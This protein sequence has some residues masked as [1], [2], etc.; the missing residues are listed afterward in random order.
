MLFSVIQIQLVKQ[1]KICILSTIPVCPNSV[2]ILPTAVFNQALY[3]F[4]PLVSKKCVHFACYCPS[5]ARTYFAATISVDFARYNVLSKSVGSLLIII[6]TKECV[7]CV[8]MPVFIVY[9]LC[10]FLPVSIF[11][12]YSVYSSL[13]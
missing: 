5:N 4:H 13:T 12:R 7:H 3:R 11:S 8:Y 6:F 9:T 10:A 1:C 2:C